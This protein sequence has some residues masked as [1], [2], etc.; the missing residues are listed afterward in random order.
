MR[1][2]F[3]WSP[4]TKTSSTK[5]PLA[6]GTL[7]MA[8]SKTSKAST[9]STSPPSQPR[10]QSRKSAKPSPKRGLIQL[11]DFQGVDRFVGFEFHLHDLRQLPSK[12][13]QKERQ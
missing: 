10:P 7:K 4:T 5:S 13:F 9:R 6:S 1:V 8:K 2:R 12:A 11:H 3:C